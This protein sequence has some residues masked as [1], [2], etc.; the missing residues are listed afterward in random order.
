MV[1]VGA[2]LFLNACSAHVS[3]PKISERE[4]SQYSTQYSS[5]LNEIRS[6]PDDNKII[7]WIQ[8]SNK[9]EP[10]KVLVGTLK[11]DDRTLAPE[12]QIF[13][14]GQC[15]NGY[16][17]GLGREFERG[18]LIDMEALAI[19]PGGKVEPKYYVEK[20]NLN[21]VI[22]E[23]DVN[24]KYVVRTSVDETGMNLNIEYTYGYFGSQDEPALI[25]IVSPLQDN[26]MFI[27]AYPN[28]TF[29]IIDYTNNEFDERM[30]DFMLLDKDKQAN[31]FGFSISKQG[32]RTAG[33]FKQGTLVR[34]VQLPQSYFDEANLIFKEIKEAGRKALEAQKKSLLVKRQYK[35]RICKDS[36]TVDFID[37]AEYNKI[38]DEDQYYSKLKE[39][40]DEEIS[41]INEIKAQKRAEL[42]Q[43][44]LIQARQMEAA[45]AQ[46]KASAAETANF[47]QSLQN[48]NQSMQNFNQNLQLQQLNNNLFMMRMGY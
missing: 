27:K 32:Y 4:I 17:Y 44:K 21:N 7:K 33:E 48:F 35:K 29:Q 5:E 22:I 12:Y 34:K 8:A 15:K 26:S 41:R 1:I 13:W 2:S 40:L 19:Y 14:D 23:G 46:R 9:K 43:Q 38:C 20:Y 25:N 30:Y 6:N 11:D 42:N 28:Y 31:G 24:G 37:N 3:L 47:N 45:A 36:I 39:R 16:A 10:C 18:V